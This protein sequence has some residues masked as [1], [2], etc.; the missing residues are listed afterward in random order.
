MVA[1]VFR[2]TRI[3]S[4]HGFSFINPTAENL[5]FSVLVP[6]TL[7]LF[8]SA[9][10]H[11]LPPTVNFPLMAHPFNTITKQAAQSYGSKPALRLPIIKV[12]RV[13]EG[14]KDVTYS[15]LYDRLEIVAKY[16]LNTLKLPH[17][18][19]VAIWSSGMLY[20]D[21][22]HIYGIMRAGYV[23]HILFSEIT[24]LDMMLDLFNQTGARAVIHL[25]TLPVSDELSKHI[26]C[27]VAPDAEHISEGECADAVVPDFDTIVVPDEDI[28]A[29]IQTSGSTSG[30]PKVVRLRQRWFEA[31]SNKLNIR[32]ESEIVVPRVGSFCHAGQMLSWI[33]YVKEQACVVMIPWNNLSPDDIVRMHNECG[34]NVLVQYAPFLSDT[35]RHAQSNPE[36]FAVLKSFPTVFYTGAA[37]SEA[38]TEWCRKNEIA[39]STALALTETGILM[40]T[41]GPPVFRLLRPEGCSYKM[42][43]IDDGVA[44]EHIKSKSPLLELVVLSD[45]GDRPDASFCDPQD[46]HFHTK[47]LFEEVTPGGYIY[48]GRLDDILIM[49]GARKLDTKYIEEQVY[50]LCESLISICVVVGAGKPS[51]A[52]LVEPSS[53][54][55]V[56]AADIVRQIGE[57][58]APINEGGFPCERINP[59]HILLLPPGELPRTPFKSNINRVAAERK[60]RSEIDALYV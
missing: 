52:L 51:P 29:I 16:W 47:D 25:P 35:I 49:K 14:W 55:I 53:A 38:D 2:R 60:F 28:I 31:N 23:P 32:E 3:H 1:A 15:Q 22:L 36:L 41:N 37:L 7:Y 24:S 44:P 46:G 40:A 30:R 9:E 20:S 5:D 26:P 10:T 11:N 13:I 50:N 18:A 19:I 17:G 43:P 27:Y 8:S 21:F 34:I 48:R 54:N 45:S 4:K 59:N 6:R 57:K 56:D 33:M 58:V 12:D 39:L 42:M